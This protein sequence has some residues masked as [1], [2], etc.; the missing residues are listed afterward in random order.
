MEEMTMETARSKLESLN[1][2]VD[3]A[4]TNLQDL[5]K[6]RDSLKVTIELFTGTPVRRSRNSKTVDLGV[7]PEELR[8]MHIR[9]AVVYIAEQN[10]GILLSTPA[11][12]LLED[13]GILNGRQNGHAL[14]NAIQESERF[15]KVGRGKYQLKV[16]DV[17]FP[18]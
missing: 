14:W 4:Q 7:E 6:K 12:K 11:R 17:D 9:E 13:A 16:N 8:D 2:K 18:F 3:R 10:E 5:I 15:D 1:K